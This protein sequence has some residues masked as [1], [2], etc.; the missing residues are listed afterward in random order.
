MTIESL[1]NGG[2][3][4]VVD[5]LYCLYC[6]IQSCLRCRISHDTEHCHYCW[7]R[8]SHF[9]KSSDTTGSLLSWKHACFAE[10]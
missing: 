8:R 1:G 4:A 6:L 2:E 3:V 10:S 7:V 5:E 9:A